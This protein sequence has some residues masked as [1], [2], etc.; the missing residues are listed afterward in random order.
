MP[1]HPK[2]NVIKKFFIKS[3]L[4]HE[5]IYEEL[6]AIHMREAKDVSERNIQCVYHIDQ[7]FNMKITDIEIF[8]SRIINDIVIKLFYE[9]LTWRN[10]V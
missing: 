6:Y 4:S 3:L 8:Y 10:N 1:A 9:N 5:I 2:N 7:Y